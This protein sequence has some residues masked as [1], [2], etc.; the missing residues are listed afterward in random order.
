MQRTAFRR[1]ALSSLVLAALAAAGSVGTVG[2]AVGN[3]AEMGVSQLEALPG[4][5]APEE[6]SA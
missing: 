4:E 6:N 2:C 5:R 1:V 3:D